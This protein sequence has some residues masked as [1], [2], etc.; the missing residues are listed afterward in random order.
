MTYNDLGKLPLRAASIKM[1]I[2]CS[3]AER[4]LAGGEA[5]R[6]HLH[7]SVTGLERRGH[8]SRGHS[9]LRTLL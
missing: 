7:G 3:G 8:L 2:D 5:Q 4:R 6:N 1:I 9:F